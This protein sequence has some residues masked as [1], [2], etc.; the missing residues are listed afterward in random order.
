VIGFASFTKILDVEK[1]GDLTDRRAD[2]RQQQDGH[3]QQI[4]EFYFHFKSV[5]GTR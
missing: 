1:I 5:A 3:K 2:T 4:A